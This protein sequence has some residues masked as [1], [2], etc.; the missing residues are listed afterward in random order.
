MKQKNSNQDPLTKVYLDKR[1]K[2][3]ETKMDKKLE[4]LETRTD[5]KT[6]K[7]SCNFMKIC[8]YSSSSFL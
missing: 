1:F 4:A 6:G 2:K 3:F 8:L 5:R 7:T